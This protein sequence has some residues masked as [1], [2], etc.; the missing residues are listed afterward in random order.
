MAKIVKRAEGVFLWVV[1]AVRNLR[2]GLQDLVDIGELERDIER[3]P[4]SIEDLYIQLLNR[5]KPMYRRD[6]ARFL[7][8]A[9]NATT[10]LDVQ[11][12]CFI[13]QEQVKGDVPLVFESFHER[14]LVEACYRMK[15]RVL[16]HTLGLLDVV[17]RHSSNGFL[18]TDDLES[19]S[20]G[21]IKIYH[22]TVRDFF[23]DNDKAKDFLREAGP[24]EH[25]C[26]SIARGTFIYLM[27]FSQY[28]RRIM[29]KSMFPHYNYLCLVM[30]WISLA[31]R[32]I[33][34]AQSDL[35]ESLLSYSS[36]FEIIEDRT[37]PMQFASA[38]K[39]QECSVIKFDV[40]GMAAYRNML[41]FICKLL[42]IPTAQ[43][44]SNPKRLSDCRYS[45]HRSDPLVLVLE[46]VSA[47]KYGGSLSSYR[48]ELGKSLRW[49]MRTQATQQVFRQRV[50]EN[51]AETYLLAC[52]Q[53][54]LYDKELKRGL[55]L[56]RMLLEA[57]A[58]P[59]VRIESSVNNLEPDT[60][61]RNEVFWANWI[62]FLM[63]Y[64]KA[65]RSSHN[66]P[67]AFMESLATLDDIFDTTKAL[68]AQGAYVNY[69]IKVSKAYCTSDNTD[70]SGFYDYVIVCEST[71]AILVLEE[72]F[73]E[74][75]EFQDF[76]TNVQR[77]FERPW[78]RVS[79]FYYAESTTGD[80]EDYGG[81]FRES[82][83]GE[84]ERRGEPYIPNEDESELLLPLIDEYKKSG[85]KIA[86]LEAF[87][88]I[89][90]AHRPDMEIDDI[91][92]MKISESEGLSEE[93]E[94]SEKAELS[95]REELSKEEK[96]LPKKEL[97]EKEL[98]EKEEH[99]RS[100]F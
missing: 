49:H 29:Q 24:E 63:Q 69:Q 61:G 32:L 9:L 23:I 71:S 25:I 77:V 46:W 97:P 3:L 35:M 47:P 86:M 20:I 43:S 59:M 37:S 92:E 79:Y 8:I 70:L 66:L 15:T 18:K 4:A 57:G 42:N 14:I 91:S 52:C 19:R 80:Y 67:A 58:D 2:E 85:E 94:L 68:L 26:L 48:R 7:Q 12:M 6:A 44:Q 39:I 89:W 65:K 55:I 83:I 40:V 76:A 90:R 64:L 81:A 82:F 73:S 31:E 34:T 22:R 11:I 10:T 1:V 38:F 72:C 95:E 17:P 74:Y 21:E 100:S 54:S 84:T 16:S 53:P 98:Q 99:R 50:S 45:Y 96:E 27:S 41:L 75:H 62:K 28:D 88:R 78:R 51:V 56:A 93:V 5:I 60:V 36:M 87:R 30:N 13:D 33:G